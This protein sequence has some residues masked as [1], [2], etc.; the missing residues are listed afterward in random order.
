MALSHIVAS[1][2]HTSGVVT[3]AFRVSRVWRFEASV[4]ISSSTST[5]TSTW[6][7]TWTKVIISW[8][9][10]ARARWHVSELATDATLVRVRSLVIWSLWLRV[11]E[12]LNVVKL[13]WGNSTFSGWWGLWSQMTTSTDLR[14]RSA[15]T[16]WVACIA[17]SRFSWVS[18]IS[19][20]SHV[21][22]VSL[23]SHISWISHVSWVSHVILRWSLALSHW[24]HLV[25]IRVLFWWRFPA[26]F[27]SGMS[28]LRLEA[29]ILWS[30]VSIYIRLLSRLNRSSIL[31]WPELLNRIFILLRISFNSRTIH[32]LGLDS[33]R[34]VSALSVLSG[35]LQFMELKLTR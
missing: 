23:V 31:L 2:A 7:S 34:L 32:R 27:W 17:S 15:G 29:I 19:W 22:W 24:L 8:V 35:L 11:Q 33:V 4:S 14:V 28:L 9:L 1:M 5:W 26:H 18:H 20:V 16:S 13:L 30:F 12:V 6:A 10:H 21:S 25:V 3:R